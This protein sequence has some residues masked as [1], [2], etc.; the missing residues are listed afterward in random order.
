MRA[1]NRAIRIEGGGFTSRRAARKHVDKRRVARW[2]GPDSIAFI[3]ADPRVNCEIQSAAAPQL[4]DLVMVAGSDHDNRPAYRY[5]DL[6]D[7]PWLDLSGTFV[8]FLPPAIYGY[9][10]V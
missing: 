3:T 5:R 1:K 8:G 7:T 9:P 6:A 2:T 10:A 4:A